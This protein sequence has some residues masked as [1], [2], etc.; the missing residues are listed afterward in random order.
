VQYFDTNSS[1][2]PTAGVGMNVLRWDVKTAD[3]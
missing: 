1:G 2:T 3:H